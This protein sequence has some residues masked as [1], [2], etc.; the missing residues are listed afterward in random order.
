MVL[1]SSGIAEQC[2]RHEKIMRFLKSRSSEAGGVLDLSLLS[3]LGLQ[4]L[5]FD[6][7]QR[8]SSPSLIC[9][10]SELLGQK[11]LMDFVGDMTRSSK[12]T[13]HPDGRILFTSSGTEMNDFLSIVAEFYSSRNSTKW[14]NKSLLIPYF[15][16]YGYIVLVD[17]F[18]MYECL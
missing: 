4:P 2:T 9:P 15:D 13:I 3:D 18:I 1:F 11:P 6:S 10:D 7:H 17:S 8:P 14:A 12:I 16:R 5:T